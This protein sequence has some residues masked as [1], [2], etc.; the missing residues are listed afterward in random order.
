MAYSRGQANFVNAVNSTD[1][2]DHR[3]NQPQNVMHAEL[4]RQ[5]INIPVIVASGP[6]Y[7]SATYPG[8]RGASVS[9]PVDRDGVGRREANSVVMQHSISPAAESAST[10]SYRSTVSTQLSS[11]AQLPL[12]TSSNDAAWSQNST[13]S[14]VGSS[15]SLPHRKR[16][17]GTVTPVE[18]YPTPVSSQIVY[19]SR[20]M[21]GQ[22][23]VA[24]KVAVASSR[25]T[26][27]PPGVVSDPT[28]VS[29]P[30]LRQIPVVVVPSQTVREQQ[31]QRV[32][33]QSKSYQE[34]TPQ[35]PSTTN[36]T[37]VSP[38][39]RSRSIDPSFLKEAEVDA[40]TDLLVQNMNVAGNPDFCGMH[41][42]LV[43]IIISDGFFSVDLFDFMNDV[44]HRY[45]A[46][47]SRAVPA[48]FPAFA[49]IHFASPGEMARLS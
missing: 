22:P 13:G 46:I 18:S 25:R 14:Y 11:T 47:A 20:M 33:R 4:S 26:G 15:S 48:Y 41:C 29:Q 39:S 38:V 28:P 19:T 42:I 24:G 1:G 5:P 6:R 16:S 8:F 12:Y 32:Y 21:P 45:K 31:E 17:D 23:G 43:V 40:L 2:Y 3:S 37:T 35:S 34:T 36:R 10:K 9:I 7:S 30:H 27:Y 44:Y 49:G